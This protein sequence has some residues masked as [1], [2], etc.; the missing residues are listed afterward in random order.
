MGI[1]TSIKRGRLQST[2]RTMYTV[3]DIIEGK[4]NKVI[5]RPASTVVT[6]EESKKVRQEGNHAGS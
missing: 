4:H 3:D 2:K 1:C 6:A 5:V